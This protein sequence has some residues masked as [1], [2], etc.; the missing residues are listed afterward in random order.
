ML[1]KYGASLDTF[2]NQGKYPLLYAVENNN[3]ELCKLLLDNN[4]NPNLY[5]TWMGYVSP[6]FSAMNINNN[7]IKELLIKYGADDLLFCYI[8]NSNFY[9]FQDLI[10][11]NNININ[12]KNSN[13]ETLLYFATSRNNLK[14]VTFLLE[15]G[16][17]PNIVMYND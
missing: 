10:Y 11:K 9:D 8:Q 4:A 7:E 17:D 3:V 13:G 6:L 14:F 2:D 1:L 12:S 15:K 16:A 5:F